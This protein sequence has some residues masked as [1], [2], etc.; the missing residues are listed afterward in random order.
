MTISETA[1]QRLTTLANFMDGLHPRFPDAFD[2]G[3]WTRSNWVCGTRACAAGWG[4]TIPQFAALGFRVTNDT[5]YFAGTTK[6]KAVAK[7]FDISFA[8]AEE[9]FDYEWKGV[10]TTPQEWAEHCRTFLAA[11]GVKH[12]VGFDKFMAKAQEPVKL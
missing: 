9:L 4:A 8:Q 12:E 1:A 6:M 3:A 11:H 5:P 10:L 7:F 2:M